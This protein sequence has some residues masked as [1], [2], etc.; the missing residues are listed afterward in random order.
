M[1]VELSPDAP[2]FDQSK[3]SEYISNM[4]KRIE[5]E[6]NLGSL[7]LLEVHADDLQIT[8]GAFFSVLSDAQQTLTEFEDLVEDGNIGELAELMGLFG[9]DI[10]SAR[11]IQPNVMTTSQQLPYPPPLPPST[12]PSPPPPPPP[13]NPPEINNVVSMST[14]LIALLS[15]IGLM[16]V[17]SLYFGC[18]YVSNRR[19]PSSPAPD[20]VSVSARNEDMPL[21]AMKFEGG[22]F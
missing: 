15:A 2:A 20:P 11:L 7:E 14:L 3:K 22:G 18:C 1:L 5:D 4:K 6:L 17:V 9:D 12:P 16:V 21:M 8:T 10:A 13:S 19:D